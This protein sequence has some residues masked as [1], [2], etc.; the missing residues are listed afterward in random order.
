MDGKLIGLP[1][2]KPLMFFGTH[3]S[4]IQWPY[5]PNEFNI[6]PWCLRKK[7]RK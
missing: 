1:I 6:F 3:R 7:D 5:V 4:S 2:G